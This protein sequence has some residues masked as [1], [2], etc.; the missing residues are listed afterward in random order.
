MYC[1]SV[2]GVAIGHGSP[3]GKRV[4]SHTWPGNAIR[5]CAFNYERRTDCKNDNLI[6]ITWSQYIPVLPLLT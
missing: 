2:S 6:M 1:L 5:A 4:L 3:L